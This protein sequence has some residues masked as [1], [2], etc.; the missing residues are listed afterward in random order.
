MPGKPLFGTEFAHD[1]E[2]H[3]FYTLKGIAPEKDLENT[4]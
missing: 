3:T 1:H 4:P 2:H